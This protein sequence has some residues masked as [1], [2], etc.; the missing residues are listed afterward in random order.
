MKVTLISES[1][2]GNCLTR[3]YALAGILQERYDVEIIGP[4]SSEGIYRGCDDGR[5]NYFGAAYSRYPKFLVEATRL[6][7]KIDGDVLLPVKLRPTSY[8]IGLLKKLLSR[9][10]IILDISDWELALFKGMDWRRQSKRELLLDPNSYLYTLWMEKLVRF[11][12]D[13][14]VTS[15]FLQRKFGGVIVPHGRDTDSFNPALFNRE[16]LR[17]DFGIEGYKIILYCGKPTEHSSLEDVVLALDKLEDSNIRLMIV[18]ADKVN[19]SIQRLIRLGRKWL[20]LEGLKPW[21]DVPRYLA[22]ADLVVL[23]QKP[24]PFIDAYMPGKLYDAMALAKP[25][26]AGG[27]SDIPEVLED[28]GIV[29]QPGDIGELAGRIKW[30]FGHPQGAEEMGERARRRCI[31]RYSWKSMGRTLINLL[32]KYE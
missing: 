7:R 32:K 27:T 15:R 1:L 4:V 12:D 9:R 6:L 5:F 19:P 11:A 20:I 29:V 8:G 13:I 10:P 16:K 2:S 22:A 28:C 3:A 18:G 30:V 14:I 23:P 26:I 21:S 24:S 17:K 25:I 31:E